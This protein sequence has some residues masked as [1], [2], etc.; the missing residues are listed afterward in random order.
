MQADRLFFKDF[1]NARNI[2]EF[3]SLYNKPVHEWFLRHVYFPIMAIKGIRFEFVGLIVFLISGVLHE[4]VFISINKRFSCWAALS[5]L[6]SGIFAKTE[7]YV[8]KN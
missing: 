4:Y 3:W 6:S 7:S 1:W 8:R 5:L 2:G